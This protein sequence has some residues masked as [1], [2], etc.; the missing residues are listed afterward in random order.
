MKQLNRREFIAQTGAA[1]AVGVAGSTLVSR[2]S[3]AAAATAAGKGIAIISDP[4][5]PIA[6]AKPAQ[7]AT[8]QLRLALDARG[9]NARVVASAAA[10]RPD[11]FC[12]LASGVALLGV[13]FPA[14]GN[15]ALPAAAEALTLTPGHLGTRE[16]LLA[17]GRDA[18]GLSYALTELAD[19]VALAPDPAAALD[20]LR[21]RAAVTERPANPIRSVI[22]V[23]ASSVED[24]GWF[25]DRAFWR[26]YLSMLAAHRFNR[27][28][29]SF[30]LGYDGGYEGGLGLRDGYLHFAYPFLV[31]VP[32]YD[33]RA[34]NLP[35][36]ERDA[37]LAMLRFIS[38]EAAARG[39]DFFLGLWTHS[40]EWPNSPNANH[41]IT[42]L[43]TQTQAPYSRDAVALILK[44]CP[45][46]SGVTFRT[47]GESGVPEGNFDFWKTIFSGLNQA[48]R[49]VTLDLHA[50]GIDQ[51]M[52]D[53]ATATGLPFTVVPKFSAEH[54]GLPYHQADIRPT[55]IPTGQPGQ[56]LYTLSEGSRSFI[57]YGY[58]DLLNVERKFGVYH[59]IWPG[60]QRLLLWGDPVFAAAYSRAGTFGGSLGHEIFDPLSFKGRKGS[61]LPGGRDGYADAS[62]RAS[63]VPNH[64]FEKY[65]YS[66]RLWGRLLYS[67]DTQPEVWRRQLRDDYGAAAAPAVETAL[68]A[69]SRIL[70]LV[71]T[72]HLVSASN[73]MYWPELYSNMP[74]ASAPGTAPFG[75]TTTPKNFGG[76]SPLDPQLFSR[77]EDYANE[78]LDSVA[79]VQQPPAAS[80]VNAK[81]S[82]AE[83]AQWLENLGQ[84]AE[85]NLAR[86]AAQVR[87][88]STPVW[89]RLT[90]DVTAQA[91]LGRF[92]AHK[93][94]AAVMFALY[95]C[96]GDVATRAAA[97]KSYQTA[98]AAWAQVAAV[99]KDVYVADLAWGD[100]WYQH[101]NWADHITHIDEDIAA[102]E[103]AAPS[104][105]KKGRT[106]IGWREGNV[107]TLVP[108]APSRQAPG[109][110]HTPPTSFRRNQPLTLTLASD[111]YTPPKMVRLHYR[112]AN[113]AERWV[114]PVPMTP[115]PGGG[116]SATIPADYTA[117]PYPLT[118]YF[119]PVFTDGRRT[120][121]P[122]LGPDLAQQPYFALMP[123]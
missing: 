60:T 36:A 49:P 16:A 118:Y 112:H 9:F 115:A 117:A 61:G 30:G 75:D 3:A 17:Q 102:M 93:L 25:N 62:L 86:A 113:H 122:G 99:T 84:V 66:Y 76:V 26:D 52:I 46:I 41:L 89:R 54:M 22:R 45:N 92:F 68:G 27:F 79:M 14:A 51:R 63:A 29:L 43:T 20:V 74:I 21:P 82:P 107:A 116:W 78:L 4:A 56:R 114:A 24:K 18:R 28:N 123:A 19:A 87:D 50:K 47:H 65:R 15:S 2:A 32:G 90:T 121:Y 53:T 44:E 73:N 77:P 111:G 8:E 35:D 67:P 72:A 57:R 71:T 80:P 85:E 70:P 37:N 88:R 108:A 42:G 69:A 23:F 105:E 94:R 64:D 120:I 10:A 34:T 48:G 81:Y 58:G 97:V 98:R 104:P 96:T 7:W 101:G 12:V 106:A 109:F 38:D 110:V 39:L 1:A 40:F 119:E 55:E 100:A 5:D 95:E 33:V 59:R 103:R 31:K 83:V 6:A 11:D 91:G 13:F